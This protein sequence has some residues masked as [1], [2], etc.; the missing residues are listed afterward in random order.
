MAA[1]K[2]TDDALENEFAHALELAGH[3]KE[4]WDQIRKQLVDV[5]NTLRA[6]PDDVSVKSC[7]VDIGGTGLRN[8]VVATIGATAVAPTIDDNVWELA[9]EAGWDEAGAVLDND[10]NVRLNFRMHTRWRTDA[11]TE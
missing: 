11:D 4:A 7:N 8:E 10:G 3:K 2:H 5:R 1:S 9:R 6:L